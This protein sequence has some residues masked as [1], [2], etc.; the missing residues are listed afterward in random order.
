MARH[1]PGATKLVVELREVC[2]ALLCV[3]IDSE[4]SD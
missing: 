4:E 3:G 1:C 2:I